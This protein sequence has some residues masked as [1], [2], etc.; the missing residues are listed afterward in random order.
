MDGLVA[1]PLKC[2]LLGV[3][4]LRRGTVLWSSLGSLS[5]NFWECQGYRACP[6]ICICRT[7][8]ENTDEGPVPLASEPRPAL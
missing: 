5:R 3:G 7:W 4:A 6:N 8:G 1:W 2:Q